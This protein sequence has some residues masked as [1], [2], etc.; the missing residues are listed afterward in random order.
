[1]K[2]ST[3]EPVVGR[4][5]INPPAVQ[6][7]RDL[8]VYGGERNDMS[9]IVAGLG[10]A[11]KLAQ[12]KQDEDD[13][14]A[15]SQ[16]KNEIRERMI[17]GLYGED[18]LFETGV[19]ENAA[20]L[21]ERVME[22]N[23]QTYQ[24]VA[25]KYNGRVQ[26][27]LLGDYNENTMNLQRISASKEFGARQQLMDDNYA[28]SIDQSGQI[29]ALNYESDGMLG[30]TIA[31][32]MRTVDAR[33]AAKHLS[34]AQYV[35]ERRKVLTSVV[36]AAANAAIDAGDFDRAD[37]ILKQHRGDMD[38][39]TWG[40]MNALVQKKVGAKKEAGLLSDIIARCKNPDGSPNLTQIYSEIDKVNGRDAKKWVADKGFGTGSFSGDTEIDSE[41]QAAAQ[42]EGIEPELLAA[43]ASHETGGTFDRG[44]V[45]PAGAIGI[46]QL[47]PDTA[48]GLGVDPNDWKQNI[49]GGAKYLKQMLDMFGGDTEKALAAYNAGPAAVKAY[50]GIPPYGE[51]QA[52]VP[53]VLERYNNYKNAKGA[54]GES[55]EIEAQGMYDASTL[56]LQHIRKWSSAEGMD[57]PWDSN[58]TTDTAH[59]KSGVAQLLKNLDQTGFDYVITGGAEAGYHAEGDYSHAHGYKVDISDDL[60]ED[61]IAALTEQVQ[62]LGGT[63]VHEADKN[64]YDIV[65]PSSR[66]AS[67]GGDGGHWESAYDPDANERMKQQARA[68]LA[69]F[70]AAKKQQSE[71]KV[72]S[73]VDAARAAGSYSGALNVRTEYKDG[74]TPEELR[75]FDSSIGTIYADEIKAAK[76]AERSTGNGS[77]NRNYS[78]GNDGDLR[79]AARGW[80][81]KLDRLRELAY[82]SLQNGRTFD[83][84]NDDHNF[85][86]Y[87][88]ALESFLM[89]QYATGDDK[90]K[91]LNMLDDLAKDYE[92]YREYWQG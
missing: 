55:E 23:K 33:A 9:A 66:S 76:E 16:A 74:M 69:D 47:M 25:S 20:G 89:T 54:G 13:Y 43:V 26:K 87:R 50:G 6:A 60:G 58:G 61:A 7:S 64:H 52:Y 88:S 70:T 83:D 79:G 12:Q 40:Q 30:S 84:T 5:T 36:G 59:F 53:D 49:R 8:N 65:I 21:T 42:E 2:F 82:Q 11:V 91:V 81:N 68:Q 90:Q 3:Y 24:D 14:I 28:S 38:Q 77:T 51:T 73:L 35:T 71:Q 10:Q 62:A 78:N 45:S 4:N 46:M 27:A 72:Q 48:A 19:G 80:F 85:E 63:I 56:G 34:G 41:I 17:Q 86:D 1:M 44:A 31:D 18:G 32:S 75:A 57:T 22:F 15:L 92:S 39:K 29:A 37:S 67:G